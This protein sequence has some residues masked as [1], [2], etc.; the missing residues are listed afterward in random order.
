MVAFG[1]HAS[2]ICNAG[3]KYEVGP[4]T[5]YYK[6]LQK[7]PIVDASTLYMCTYTDKY[8]ILIVIN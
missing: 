3:K 8:Y 1:K 4:V 7:V 5:T 2:I 6:V